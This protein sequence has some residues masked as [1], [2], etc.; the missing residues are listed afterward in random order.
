[1]AMHIRA[2]LRT[3]ATEA[4]IREALLQRAF[5]GF[6]WQQKRWL[7]LLLSHHLAFDHTSLEIICA[8]VHTHLLGEQGVYQK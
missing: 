3:G 5:I 2:T 8:E 1:M 6:A 7:L 4:D